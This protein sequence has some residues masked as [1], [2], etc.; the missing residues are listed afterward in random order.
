MVVQEKIRPTTAELLFFND[1]MV[2]FD[3]SCL[4][5]FPSKREIATPR[6]LMHRARLGVRND[7]PIFA[8]V[9]FRCAF[10]GLLYVRFPSKREIATPRGLA[11]RARLGARNDP[12]FLSAFW[13]SCT[14]VFP[15]KREIATPR[16]LMHRA[17]LGVRNDTHFVQCLSGLGDLVCERKPLTAPPVEASDTM[18]DD[19]STRCWRH[20]KY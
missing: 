19:S 13:V 3:V 16:G 5:V 20:K 10:L 8:F 15:S 2:P 17:R 11:H 1:F 4:S 12:H 7:T 9:L 18:P 6:G 14:S